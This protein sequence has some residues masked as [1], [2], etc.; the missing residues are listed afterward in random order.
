MLLLLLSLFSRV[1]LL[2]TPWTAAYQA[3]PSMGFPR[4]LEWGA[5]AF[6]DI[7]TTIYKTDNKDLLYSTR[8]CS[9]Y[10][11]ISYM[12]KESE[13]DICISLCCTTETNTIL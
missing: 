2:A 12:G 13:K 8:N 4:V 1:Q 3:P 6:S 9:Q 7:Y 10:S 11:V 5:I